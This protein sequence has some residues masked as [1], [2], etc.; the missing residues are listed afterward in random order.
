MCGRRASCKITDRSLVEIPNE[1]A[2]ISH[3]ITGTPQRN[4]NNTEW[5]GE[6][7]FNLFILQSQCCMH[8]CATRRS[9]GTLRDPFPGDCAPGKTLVGFTPWKSTTGLTRRG[10]FTKLI[11]AND[12]LIVLPP[13]LP[14]R[15]LLRSRAGAREFWHE[16]WDPARITGY[17]DPARRSK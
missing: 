8:V 16:Q 13:P 4:C 2:R 15:V 6:S 5:P 1:N 12:A 3:K 7:I 11:D 14:T 9:R 17:I 10:S